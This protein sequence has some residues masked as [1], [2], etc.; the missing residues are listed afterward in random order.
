MVGLAACLPVSHLRTGTSL[1][2]TAAGPNNA[3]KTNR[4]KLF[5]SEQAGA[6]LT[7]PPEHGEAPEYFEVQAEPSARPNVAGQS[8][9]KRLRVSHVRP[10]SWERSRTMAAGLG[11]RNTTIRCVKRNSASRSSRSSSSST[12][13]CGLPPS[14]GVAERGVAHGRGWVRLAGHSRVAL[15]ALG[16][17]TATPT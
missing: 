4:F 10:R 2:F 13:L 7:S 15:A 16:C 5:P 12:P 17:G 6:G 11:E 3:G 9:A 14:V 8:L 1:S